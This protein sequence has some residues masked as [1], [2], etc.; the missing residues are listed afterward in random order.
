MTENSTIDAHIAYE[1]ID[2]AEPKVVVIEFLSHSI[3]DPR[4]VRELGEQLRSLIRPDL[5]RLFVIDFKHVRMLGSR[6]FGE[7]ASFA[8][9]C[10]RQGAG[11]RSAES[12]RLAGSVLP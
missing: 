11:S 3:I 7:I 5:P 10:G 4:H 2:E 6:A 12:T 1:L 9:M 8:Q